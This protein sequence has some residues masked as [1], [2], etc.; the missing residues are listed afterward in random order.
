MGVGSETGTSHISVLY[1]DQIFCGGS[2]TGS[3]IKGSGA[4]DSV[5]FA[6][7]TGTSFYALVGTIVGSQAHGLGATPVSVQITPV[8]AFG[9]FQAPY[10]RAAADS[11]NTFVSAGTV[12]T[13]QITVIA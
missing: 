8:F 11:T 5:S 6:S 1:A 13:V 2:V 12:G 7:L 10:Q 4:N 9:T 3:V